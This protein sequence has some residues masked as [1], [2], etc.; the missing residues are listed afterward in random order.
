VRDNRSRQIC[1]RVG[2][3]KLWQLAR[4]YQFQVATYLELKQQCA[5]LLKLVDEVIKKRTQEFPK[6]E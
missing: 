5:Q 3:E 6:D 4:N 1:L 2:Q